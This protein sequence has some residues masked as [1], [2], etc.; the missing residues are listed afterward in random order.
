MNKKLQELVI[1][2]IEQTSD[3]EASKLYIGNEF[4][5]NYAELI[6]RECMKICD[7]LSLDY[8]YGDGADKCYND[9]STYFGVE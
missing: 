9:I 3:D 5:S 8:V 2:A 6:I 4:A 1:K 7:E